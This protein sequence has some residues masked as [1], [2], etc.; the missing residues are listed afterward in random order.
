[1]VHV[2]DFINS[3]LLLYCYVNFNMQYTTYTKF[4]EKE[5]NIIEC[6]LYC[7]QLKSLVKIYYRDK[8]VITIQTFL[9]NV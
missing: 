9:L 4:K 7:F 2:I 8:Y 3:I 5:K 6:L 1:V